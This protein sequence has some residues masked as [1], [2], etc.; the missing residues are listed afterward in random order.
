MKIRVSEIFHSIQ[1]E[2]SRTGHP[3]IFIRF[4]GCP[5][6]CSFC[7]T[8]HTWTPNDAKEADSSDIW[9]HACDGTE[10]DP[11]IWAWMSVD[12]IK[13]LCESLAA[14]TRTQVVITGGEPLVQMKGLEAL[15]VALTTA[16]YAVQLETSGT[17]VPSE[18]LAFRTYITVSPKTGFKMEAIEGADELKF[19]VGPSGFDGNQITNIDAHRY[20]KGCPIYLQPESALD[21]ATQEA[22]QLCKT[23][24]Y[25]MSLQTHKIMDVQ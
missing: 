18:L 5:V 6:G 22:V 25:R 1:G 19:V 21:D 3:S 15:V 10:A 23:H 2:G 17:I 4:Q 11:K 8:R 20:T 16:G 7:D 12:E 13:E 24:G 14:C 9:K